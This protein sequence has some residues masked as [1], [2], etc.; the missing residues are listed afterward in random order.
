ME[1][2]NAESLAMEQVLSQKR[3][4][5]RTELKLISK[6]LAIIKNPNF[7]DSLKQNLHS[8]V[9]EKLRYLKETNAKR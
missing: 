8:L 7:L 1:E 5:I 6:K 9:L 4:E 3:K 2:I